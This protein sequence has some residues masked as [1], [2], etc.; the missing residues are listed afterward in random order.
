M[1][2]GSNAG[3]DRAELFVADFYPKLGEYLAERHAR[4]YDAVAARARFLFWLAKHVDQGA[5]RPPGA[6]PGRVDPGGADGPAAARAAG[7]GAIA[8]NALTDY[9]AEVSAMPQ[10]DRGEITELGKRIAA[11]RQAEETLAATGALTADERAVLDRVADQGLRAKNRLLETHLRLVV[12]VAERYA[13]RGLPLLALVQ[14][15]NLGLTKAVERFDD[16]KGYSFSAYAIWWI[17]QAIN[18]A[19][20]GQARSTRSPV[21]VVEAISEII[22]LQHRLAR[23]LGREP[24]PEELAAE[25]GT[26]PEGLRGVAGPLRQQE[27]GVIAQA[28]GLVVEHRAHQAPQYFF[29]RLFAG[30]FPLK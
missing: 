24:T 15:G 8:D 26:S 23:E 17:R 1:S 2:T 19:L 28:T 30:C 11:G 4:G 16:S 27:G 20:A 5:V 14:E 21:H 13:G 12:G 18:R 29:W 6:G 22:L 3:D 10:P 25:L 7:V 9:I